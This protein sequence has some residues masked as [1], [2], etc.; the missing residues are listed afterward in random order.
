MVYAF[1]EDEQDSVAARLIDLFTLPAQIFDIPVPEG[2]ISIKM[3][4]LNDKENQEVSDM[5]DRFGLAS[6]LLVERRYILS[7]AVLWI[8]NVPVQMPESVRIA[9]KEG[10][11]RDPTDIEQKLWVF[12]QC[13]PVL[14]QELMK[15][16]D[17]MVLAQQSELGAIKKKFAEQSAEPPKEV[18]SSE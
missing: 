4:L 16:Y 11:G 17:E 6:R 1:A 3:R 7:R 5:A 10:I 2:S 8:E 9:A 13:Q 15:H 12:E 18:K 14:L